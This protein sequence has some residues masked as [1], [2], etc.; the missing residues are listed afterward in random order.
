MQHLIK[1]FYMLC[2]CTFIQNEDQVLLK[3]AFHNRQQKGKITGHGPKVVVQDYSII[4]VI[5]IFLLLCVENLSAFLHIPTAGYIF[6]VAKH[7]S[8]YCYSGFC[9][10]MHIYIEIWCG[11]CAPLW[12]NSRRVH[13][14]RGT[15]TF[16]WKAEYTCQI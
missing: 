3:L 13:V 6:N 4:T 16:R 8:V 15:S 1:T 14:K 10:I 12:N 2:V 7:V 9:I 5:N 11:C